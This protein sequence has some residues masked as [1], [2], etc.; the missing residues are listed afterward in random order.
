MTDPLHMS[1]LEA[2]AAIR[3]KRISSFEL[4]SA[5]LRRANAL[6]NQLNVF[7][8]LDEE[9]ALATA[10]RRDADL[11]HGTWRGALHG[12]PLAHKDMFYRRGRVST[13][14]SRIRTNWVAEHT[15]TVLERLDASGAVHLG[16][17]NMTEFAYTPIGQNAFLGDVKNPWNTEFISG[18]SSSG[19]GAAVGARIVFGA[20]GSDTGGSI[21]LPASMCGVVGLKPT[22]ASVPSAGAMPLSQ[23]LDTIGGLTRTVD[24][25]VALLQVIQGRDCMAHAWDAVQGHVDSAS[26]GK[27]RPVAKVR[28]GVPRGYFDEGVDPEISHLLAVAVETYRSLGVQPVE[29]AMPDLDAINAVGVMLTWGDVLSVH[30]RWMRECGASYDP[31]T[32]TRIELALACSTE[33]FV[34]AQRL[35]P[36][37]LREFVSSVFDQCDALLTPVL[38]RVVPS[39]SEVES[40]QSKASSQLNDEL[41]RFTRPVNTLGLPAL[42]MPCGFTRFG[43]PCGM[44]LIG[45]PFAEPLL[46]QLGRHYQSVTDWHSRSPTD[47]ELSADASGGPG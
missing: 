27:T 15:A 31:R 35:R 34:D 28:L 10:L 4:T 32:R 6:Q 18:G 39:M 42:S 43:L 47:F 41:T 12:V 29:V 7:V 26:A 9:E 38:A 14:G 30:R 36:R 44:Q 17:L 21:R 46:Y 33:D 13:C 22:Y 2:A 3:T 45:R 25:N 5:A 24:D 37:L 1:L 19:S 23:S 40:E 20:L 11:A 16:T 8:D